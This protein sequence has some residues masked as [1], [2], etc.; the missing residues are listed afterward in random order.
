MSYGT[1]IGRYKWA[2]PEDKALPVLNHAYTRGL[3]F[4]DTANI[5]ANGSS[6]EILGKVI[7]K[8]NWRRESLVIANT[9]WTPVGQGTEQL[10][11][12]G[13]NKEERDANS[14]PKQYGLS[15]KQIFDSIDASLSRLGLPY[16][17][18][19]QVHRFDPNTPV[20]ETME[21]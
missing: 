7:K 13:V 17:E 15:R 11:L 4:F 18:L 2:L 6:E 9:A 10:P 20:K 5:Y 1:P 3:N 14:Y 12:L 8:H 16:V 19:L 21:A